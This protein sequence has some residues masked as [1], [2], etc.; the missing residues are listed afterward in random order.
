MIATPICIE[1]TEL[2]TNHS[3]IQGKSHSSRAHRGLVRLGTAALTLGVVSCATPPERPARPGLGVFTTSQDIGAAELPG[4]LDAPAPNTYVV[5]GA[6]RNLWGAQDEFH[7]AF[8]ELIGDAQIAADI[9]LGEALGQRYRKALLMFRTSTKPDAAYVDVAVHENG[10]GSLQYR[11]YAGAP[12]LDLQSRVTKPL[13]V[14]L[15]RRGPYFHAEFENASGQRDEV[16]P[17][18]VTLPD[19]ALVGVGVNSAD[20]DHLARVTFSNLE[21]SQAVSLAAFE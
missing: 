21:L 16:G 18:A 8:T 5:S 12:T 2:M 15:V 19:A 17:I 10:V 4:Q 20:T 7:F 13:H 11:P 9:D 1:G 14:R 6:G 3:N